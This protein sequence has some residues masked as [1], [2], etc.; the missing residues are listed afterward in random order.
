[1][2]YVYWFVLRLGSS[3]VVAVRISLLVEITVM[4]LLLFFKF[5]N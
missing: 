1:M 4:A 3:Q 2:G 5:N